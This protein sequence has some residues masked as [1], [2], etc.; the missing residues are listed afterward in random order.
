MFVCP[1]ESAVKNIALLVNY[2]WS[3]LV[4]ILMK[5]IIVSILEVNERANVMKILKFKILPEN[6]VCRKKTKYSL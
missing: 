4:I 3:V 6:D 2:C 5:E 1:N